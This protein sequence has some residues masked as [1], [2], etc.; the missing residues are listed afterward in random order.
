MTKSVLIGL[1]I[2]LCVVSGVTGYFFGSAKNPEPPHMSYSEVPLPDGRVIRVPAG[3]RLRV[4]HSMPVSHTGAGEMSSSASGRSTGGSKFNPAIGDI[5]SVSAPALDL[6]AGAEHGSGGDLLTK[7]AK[8]AGNGTTILLIGG[9][10]IGV[11]GL[12]LILVF[13]QM[14]NG[15]VCL[16]AGGAVIATA[17]LVQAYPWVLLVGAAA[18][19]VV[20]GWLLYRAYSSGKLEWAFGQVVSG[21]EAAPADAGAEVKASIADTSDN[22]IKLKSVVSAVKARVV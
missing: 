8:A 12:V 6:T 19:L 14:W 22:A 5:T 21:V 9:L 7:A 16:V 2:G 10:V 20:V 1:V 4:T 13:K 11:V 15:F 18:I 17:L 3:H